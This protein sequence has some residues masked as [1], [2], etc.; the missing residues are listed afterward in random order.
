MNIKQLQ[1][2][3]KIYQKSEEKKMEISFKDK[4]GEKK[5]T[6]AEIKKMFLES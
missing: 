4:D 2:R 5:I 1:T 6:T 3:K